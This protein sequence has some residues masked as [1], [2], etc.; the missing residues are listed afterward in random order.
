MT[1]EQERQD[2]YDWIQEKH[3]DLTGLINIAGIL[4][5]MSTE[6]EAYC[7]KANE[8]TMLSYFNMMNP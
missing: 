6:D 7:E 5:W 4:H 8:E 3:S 1:E 2:L